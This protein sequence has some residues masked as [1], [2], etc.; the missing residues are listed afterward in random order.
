MSNKA[1]I[2]AIPKT[3]TT[4]TTVTYLPT[5]ISG[6]RL[7]LDGADAATITQSGGTVSQWNDKSGNGYN[8]TQGTTA[9][10]PT[11]VSGGTNGLSLLRFN[12]TDQYLGGGTTLNIGTSDI[13]IFAVCKYASDASLQS[14]YI[15]AKSL[16]GGAAARI[17]FGVQSM[18]IGD[19]TGGNI[20]WQGSSYESSYASYHSVEF[21]TTR[22]SGTNT[23]YANGSQ[24]HQISPG[25]DTSTNWTSGYNMIVGGYNNGSGGISPPQSGLYMKGDICE[26]LLYAATITTTQRQTIEA[27]L[28]QKW[29]LTASLPAGH[30][31]LTSLIHGT[32]TVTIAVP[33]QKISSIPKAAAVVNFLPTSITGCK[34][35][36]DAYDA[37]YTTTGTTVTGW[38][39]KTGNANAS[40]GGGTVSIN[41]ATLG[42]K[43]SV[44]F[45]AGTNY[46][47]V[48]SLSYSTAYRNQFFVVTVGASGSV[49]VYLNC[50]DGI[51]GQCYSWSD[52]DIEMNKSGTLGL[53][54]YP[55]GFFSST[56]I[57]SICTSSGSNTGIWVNGT[58]KTLTDNNTGTGGFWSTGSG[59][60]TLGGIS[61]ITAGT[62]DIYE[63]LQYDGILTTTQRQTIESYLAQKWGLTAYLVAG[64]PGLTTTVYGTTTPTTKLKIGYLPPVIVIPPFPYS[65]TS[66]LLSFFSF[67]NSLLDS[68]STITLAATGSISYVAGRITNQAIYLANETQSANSSVA[69][70]YL[71]S[72]Y[73]LPTTFSVSVWFN[74]TNTNR[75]SLL[76]TYNSTG[77]T[78]NSINLYIQGGGLSAAY[79]AVANVG[80]SYGVGTGTWYH[81]VIILNGTSL[82]LYVNGSQVGSTIT[83][84]PSINGIMIGQIYDGSNYPFSGYIDDYR[85]YS[86]AL[87]G[88]EISS[89][90]AG[91]G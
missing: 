67:D 58:N 71:S 20:W 65:I 59:A 8:F 23:F 50:N 24:F 86:R 69:N 76:S 5:S 3:T 81:A 51:C 14:S 28:A 75:G 16:Y 64:H 47:N 43:S 89:I 73:N 37:S 56:A 19:G 4:T 72:S 2:V 62:T 91:T 27:Y 57:V 10:Q 55:T 34:V 42:G 80:G 70:N 78:R 88:A 36:F 66:G 85:I 90:Y 31:G 77:L 44:R 46:L 38:T 7:W 33:K 11:F 32:V 87:S 63:L 84:T 53:R 17:L 79:N 30:P 29:G 45:P 13:A 68:K 35:W 1:K 22:A 9:Y 60:P 41:L 18:G 15:F 40:T 39:N 6:C 12:G 61:G 74:P 49:Y 48:G 82:S 21:V 54:A 26:I 25:V 52:G 83:G